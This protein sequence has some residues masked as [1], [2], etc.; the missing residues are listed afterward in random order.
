MEQLMN[1]W[2]KWMKNLGLAV[3]MEPVFGRGIDKMG[4]IDNVIKNSKI[5]ISETSEYLSFYYLIDKKSIV[6][7]TESEDPDATLPRPI[8]RA[9]KQKNSSGG[10]K[11]PLSHKV[12]GYVEYQKLV[13]PP[14]C[15]PDPDSGATTYVL[16]AISRDE[17]FKGWGIGK[18]ISFLSVCIIVKKGGYITSDRDTSDQAGSELVKS[19]KIVGAEFSKPFDYVG[20]LKNEIGTHWEKT[21]KAEL[22]K[23]MR[24]LSPKSKHGYEKRIAKLYNH[25]QPLT[26]SLE[27]DCAP[28][29]NIFIGN[30]RISD[31]NDNQNRFVAGSFIKELDTVEQQQ[32]IDKLLKMSSEQIQDMLNKDKNVQGYRFTLSNE[33]I[34]NSVIGFINLINKSTE[35]T[36]SLEGNDEFDRYTKEGSDMFNRVYWK[37]VGKD[38]QKLYKNFFPGKKKVSTKVK[39]RIKKRSQSNNNK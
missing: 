35:M 25:L 5:I 12:A 2:K 22:G 20:W 37:E 11:K 4:G 13:A 29:I 28:S 10:G 19:L 32:N 39:S 38:K 24:K 33:E 26:D 31:K 27:D 14:K 1:K 7:M 30:K 6:S 15:S 34:I 18:L 8:N 17:T 9:G 16:K 3:W 23:G 21:I 36:S